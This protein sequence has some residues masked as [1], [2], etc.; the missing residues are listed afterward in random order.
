MAYSAVLYCTLQ[1]FGGV[2]LYTGGRAGAREKERKKKGRAG[3]SGA[4]QY[5]AGQE[6]T[7]LY[8]SVQFC[9]VMLPHSNYSKLPARSM[10]TCRALPWRRAIGPCVARAAESLERARATAAAAAGATG[11]GNNNGETVQYLR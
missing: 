2:V 1:T 6:G 9:T 4:V 11:G 5:N 3:G 8:S 7:V 10:T